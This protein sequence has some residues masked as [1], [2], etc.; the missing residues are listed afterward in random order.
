MV[1]YYKELWSKRSM[2]LTPITKLTGKNSKFEWTDECQTAFVTMKKI[3]AQ[4][5]LLMYPECGKRF[6]V[7]TDECNYQIG[8]VISQNGKPVAYFSR[9]FNQT[10]YRYTTAEKELLAIVETLK[11]YRQVLLGQEIRIYTDHKNLT[12]PSTDF[13]SDRISRQRLVIEEYGVELVY[14]PGDNNIVADTLSRND[15]VAETLEEKDE[16][17]LS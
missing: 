5:V 12:Y 1:N 4:G 16:A 13:A 9:K 15:T 7:H 3:M 11:T 17:F 8:A 6:D 14:V 2:V 10:Q